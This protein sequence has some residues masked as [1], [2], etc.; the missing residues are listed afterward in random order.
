MITTEKHEKRFNIP[1]P[2]P[3]PK[4]PPPIPIKRPPADP[5]Q[6]QPAKPAAR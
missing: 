6:N 2:K 3:W 5:K 4:I 1:P